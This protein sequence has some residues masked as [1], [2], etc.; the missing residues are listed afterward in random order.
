MD[1]NTPLLILGGACCVVPLL[2]FIAGFVVRGRIGGGYRP[3][4]Y[5]R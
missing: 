1:Q 3:R 4:T 5:Y 2:A